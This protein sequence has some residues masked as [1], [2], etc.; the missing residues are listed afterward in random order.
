MSPQRGAQRA[1]PVGR[2]PERAHGR[3]VPSEVAGRP[4]RESKDHFIAGLALAAA[5]LSAYILPKPHYAGANL[6]PKFAALQTLSGWTS[7]DV[8]ATL[9]LDD[10]RYNFISDVFARTYTAPDGRTLLFLILDAGNFHHPKVCFTSAGFDV[11]ELRDFPVTSGGEPF[12]AKALYASKGPDAFLVLY[13]LAIDGRVVDWTGQKFNQFWSSLLH[14][15]RPG[16]MVR[17]DIPIPKDH[18]EKA[19]AFAQ[20]FLSDVSRTLPPESAP[21]LFGSS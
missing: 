15:R 13:W 21:Y 4:W 11:K 7:R 17:L 19:L 5:F 6:L 16:L 8:A 2:N 1:E 9:D 12:A 18:P 3:S 10:E 14:K 20:S